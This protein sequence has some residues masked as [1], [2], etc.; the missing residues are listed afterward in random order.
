MKYLIKIFILIFSAGILLIPSQ[1]LMAQNSS[2]KSCCVDM[3]TFH[4]NVPVKNSKSSGAQD[5]CSISLAASQVLH[6]PENT[7]V[8]LKQS[9]SISEKISFFVSN[10]SL[11]NTVFDVLFQ[12]PRFN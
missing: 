12:P 7:L 9:D 8:N 10:E 5:C 3:N 2:Q 6:Q 11:P 1:N 4:K